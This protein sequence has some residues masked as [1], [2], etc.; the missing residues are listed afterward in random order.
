MEELVNSKIQRVITGIQEIWQNYH[1][2]ENTPY[3]N[4]WEKQFGSQK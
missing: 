2:Y 4:Q 1:I 3:F